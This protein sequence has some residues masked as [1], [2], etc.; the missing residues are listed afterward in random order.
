M[1][2]PDARAALEEAGFRPR[3]VARDTT[4]PSEEGIVLEQDPSGTTEAARGS[5]VTIY[6]GRL[7]L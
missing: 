7:S 6:V 5:T 1:E 3:G 4:E 2:A